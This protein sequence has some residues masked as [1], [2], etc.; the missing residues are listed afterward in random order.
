MEMLTQSEVDALI[1]QLTTGALVKPAEQ[2]EDPHSGRVRL[3]DFRRPDKFS[4]DQLR[5]IQMIHDA[6]S[7]QLSGYLAGKTRHVVQ[8]F[9]TS[10]DQMTYA[11]F[12]RGVSNPGI[13][14]VVNM[15][16]LSGS[17]LM[18]VTPNV[19]FAIVDRMLGGPGVAI[20]KS[21]PLTEI[22][23]TIIHGILAGVVDILGDSWKNIIELRPSLEVIE[24]NPLFVQVIAP[25]EMVVV[26]SMET[27][28]G[29]TAGAMNLCLPYLCIE[30]VLPRLSAHQWFSSA[31]R[32]SRE[33]DDVA[34]RL[35]EVPVPVVAELGEAE[36]TVDELLNLE[37]GD[38]VVL[39]QGVDREV[40]VIVDGRPKLL[41][42]PG[43]SGRRVAVLVTRESGGVA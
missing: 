11:E 37:P 3:Y 26:V 24:T 23:V 17:A 14:G 40:K 6:L 8:M 12:L 9:I 35:G 33:G 28:I 32:G 29:E 22:E 43:R 39:K 36:I 20:G 5:T 15:A 4:K 18:E 1:S 21:R 30:P 27:R 19:G 34:S 7:R 13:I 31:Q 41:G 16:P 10:V 42:K 2:R 25:N 38:V